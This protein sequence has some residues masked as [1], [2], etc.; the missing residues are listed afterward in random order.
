MK[1]RFYMVMVFAVLLV[2]APSVTD[3]YAA[4]NAEAIQKK[5]S[6]HFSYFYDFTQERRG[7]MPIR[8]AD[9]NGKITTLDAYKGKVIVL[10]F[11][12]TWCPP[13]IKELPKL[14]SF[15]ETWEGRGVTVVPVSLDYAIDPVKLS[16]FMKKNNV[17]ALPQLTVPK[18]DEAWTKL[19]SFALP[20]TFIVDAGGR[21]LYKMTGDADWTNPDTQAF[22]ENL[23]ANQK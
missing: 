9:Q 19:T 22:F 7:V 16:G 10:H 12:A 20:V 4:G 3:A 15:K 6:S 8:F 13:C 11:W 23:L 17:E 1:L 2:S 5:F 21:V 14:Q 18:D